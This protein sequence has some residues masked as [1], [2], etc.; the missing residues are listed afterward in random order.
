ML[1]C[2][3][4]LLGH[5]RLTGI[6]RYTLDTMQ[7]SS[8]PFRLIVGRPSPATM[9]V[10]N[11]ANERQW[12]TT[13]LTSQPLISLHVEL[14]YRLTRKAWASRGLHYFSLAPSLAGLRHPFSMTI[15]DVSAWRFPE[16][17]SKGMR[18]LYRPLIELASAAPGL[19]GVITVS[20]FSREEIHRVL[21]IDRDKI[22]VV[23]PSISWSR[24][25]IP[26]PLPGV[27][28]PFYLH[29]GTI[30][31]RKDIEMLVAAFNQAQLRDVNL[32]LVGR[33]GWQALKRLPSRVHYI[34]Q[35]QDAHL[36]WLYHR[37][38]A[39]VS[40]SRYEGFGLPP[41]EALSLSCP[42]ILRDIPV[43][44]ELF[45]DHPHCA[46][47][48]ETAEL[49]DLLRSSTA[50]TRRTSLGYRLPETGVLFDRAMDEFY[51]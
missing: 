38:L 24:H 8:G 23:Y 22:T 13:H 44:R 26:K 31:P 21:G 7:A 12:S 30:E 28:E 3:V 33:Q 48:S 10:V 50:G 39:L 43:Y 41:A 27:F 29:V 35:V 20:Q 37:A 6:E 4:L 47:F 9:A 40:T 42:V 36:V 15:H 1:A 49:V 5:D 34:G 14:G 32:Y 2:E 19:R 45:K 11:L 46:M 16:T 51:T 18:Y 25:V 17:M